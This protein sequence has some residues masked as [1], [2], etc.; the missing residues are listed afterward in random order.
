MSTAFEPAKGTADLVATE[1]LF[2]TADYTRNGDK[3]IVTGKDYRAAILLA[4]KGDSIP[5]TVWKQLG[6]DLSKLKVAETLEAPPGAK[7]V[8]PEQIA[9]RTTRP[10]KPAAER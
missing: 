9:S 5:A 6:G 7:T 8:A 2:L 10:E 4:R 3:T 1:D